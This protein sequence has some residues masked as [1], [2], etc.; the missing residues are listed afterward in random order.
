M[1]R[2]PP[3]VKNGC[4]FVSELDETSAL[5]ATSL[6]AVCIKAS[7]RPHEVRTD[8]ADDPRDAI[9]LSRRTSTARRIP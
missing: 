2:T 9:G 8:A 7:R 5:C 1:R 4:P 3:C 6:R